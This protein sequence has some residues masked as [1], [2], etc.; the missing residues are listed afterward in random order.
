VSRKDTTD[1][2][3]AMSPVFLKLLAEKKYPII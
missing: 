3:K 2:S 1:A